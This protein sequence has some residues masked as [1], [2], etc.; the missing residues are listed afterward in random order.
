MQRNPSAGEYVSDFL[1]NYEFGWKTQW[2]DN[3]VQFNGALFHQSWDDIQVSFTGEN[4]ITAVNNGPTAEVN[5]FEGNLIWLPTE[6]L[7]I[8]A[9]V[10]FYD[11]ELKDDYCNFT[12]G[13]CT[14]VLAPKGTSLPTTADFKGNLIARYTFPIGRF[15]AHIQGAVA[16]NGDRLGDLDQSVFEE[17]PWLDPIKKL[18]AWTT[19]SLPI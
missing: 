16:H 11:T 18:P 9:G 5:G 14:E 19:Y 8:S 15:D 10:A 2:L 6:N 7:R 13:V 4:A 12:A 1:T 3:S 17:R